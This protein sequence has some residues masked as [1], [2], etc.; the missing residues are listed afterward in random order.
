MQG[1]D[2]VSSRARTHG[3]RKLNSILQ[4]YIYLQYVCGRARVR[5]CVCVCDGVCSS[6]NHIIVFNSINGSAEA[7]S[8]VGGEA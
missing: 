1:E 3:I 4:E 2:R 7:V 6:P 8:G 5:V